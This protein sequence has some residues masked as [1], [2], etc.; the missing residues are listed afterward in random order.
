MIIH[1]EY[2]KE[3][4]GRPL[5]QCK[6]G[7]GIEG[8][9]SVTGWWIDYSQPVLSGNQSFWVA[10]VFVF[11]SAPP[12]ARPPIVCLSHSCSLQRVPS[13]LKMMLWSRTSPIAKKD[14]VQALSP[15][16]KGSVCPLYYQG[17]RIISLIKSSLSCLG[18]GRILYTNSLGLLL[19][20]NC[21]VISPLLHPHWLKIRR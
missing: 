9:Y 3:W 1:C 10:G 16:L 13:C 12:S 8:V 5:G 2:P 4:C 21:Y 20:H 11:P 6:W 18:E 19:T 14:S 17:D 15:L 7:S